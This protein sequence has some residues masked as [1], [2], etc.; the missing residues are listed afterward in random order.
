MGERVLIESGLAEGDVVVVAGAN[1]IRA[2]Q[3]VRVLN[4]VEPRASSGR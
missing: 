2:G 4:E 3:Q 1:L